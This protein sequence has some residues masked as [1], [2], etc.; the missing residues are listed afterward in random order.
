MFMNVFSPWYSLGQLSPSKS[1]GGFNVY[2]LAGRSEGG[3]VGGAL[4]L[5]SLAST[6]SSESPFGIAEGFD[7]LSESSSLSLMTGSAK[8][9]RSMGGLGWC[10]ATIEAASLS[11]SLW[12]TEGRLG[13]RNGE[14]PLRRW[15]GSTDFG[16]GADGGVS[17]L[18]YE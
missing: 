9:R 18:K 8:V 2:G 4:S 7:A 13:D 5:G 15:D 16:L 3:G 6:S 1:I 17:I 10:E 12:P 11:R 14:P